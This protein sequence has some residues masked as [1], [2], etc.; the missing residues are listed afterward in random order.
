M[1]S[2]VAACRA[3]LTDLAAPLRSPGRPLA[4]DIR[5]RF[6]R[7]F[8]ELAA[9]DR[10]LDSPAYADPEFRDDIDLEIRAALLRIDNDLNRLARRMPPR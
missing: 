1:R 7:I 2:R 4:P 8:S 6:E 5:R 9:M 10:D 3:R